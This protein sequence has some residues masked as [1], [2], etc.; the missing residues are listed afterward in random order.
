MF[1]THP[2]IVPYHFLADYKHSYCSLLEG[3]MRALCVDTSACASCFLVRNLRN[4]SL[5][6]LNCVICSPSCYSN[7]ARLFLNCSCV[8]TEINLCLFQ[9]YLHQDFSSYDLRFSLNVWCFRLKMLTLKIQN[10]IYS[11]ACCVP[12]LFCQ[13]RKRK[14]LRTQEYNRRQI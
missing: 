9:L 12:L 11:E 13:M 3:W 10:Q 14:N 4:N 7:P 8:T 1:Q 6:N 5:K 2:F